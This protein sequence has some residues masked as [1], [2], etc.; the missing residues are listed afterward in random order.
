MREPTRHAAERRPRL[1]YRRS[2][3]N[4]TVSHGILVGRYRN[5]FNPAR[6]LS[7][8]VYHP[9]SNNSAFDFDPFYGRFAEFDSGMNDRELFDR[10]ADDYDANLAAALEVSGEDRNFFAKGRVALLSQCLRKLSEKPRFA[11]DFGCGDG[12]TAPVLREQLDLERVLGVDASPRSI[13][14]ARREIED[15]DCRFLDMCDYTPDGVCD[16]A[17]CNGVFHHISPDERPAAIEFVFRALRAGGIF[18]L[19][20]NNPWNPGTRYVMSR[21]VFDKDA[22]PLAP[23]EC[24]RILAAAGFRILRTDYAFIFPHAL[25]WLRLLENGVRKLPLGAQYQVLARKP[26]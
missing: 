22:L 20:E 6:P 11:L 14:R 26:S 17:Y 1:S 13:Q 12:S 8:V 3:N 10:Y 16:M 19:W 18:A 5:R 4:F 21:C 24:R 25:S 2:R 23:P 9:R 7:G 15:P